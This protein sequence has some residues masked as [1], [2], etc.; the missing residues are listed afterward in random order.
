[1][2]NLAGNEVSIFLFRFERQENALS[3]VLNETIAEDLYPDTQ[4]QLLPLIHV[5]CEILLRYRH[6]CRTNT[7]MDMNI[8]MDGDLEVMLSPG[9]GRYFPDREK[10]YLSSDAHDMAKIL[11]DVMARRSQEREVHILLQAPVSMPL[12]LM[13]IDEQF[14]TLARERQHERR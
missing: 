3:F 1:M 5:C 11:M 6:R 2:K 4:T 12:E 14:E 9:L 13:S 8:L 10:L 7:I